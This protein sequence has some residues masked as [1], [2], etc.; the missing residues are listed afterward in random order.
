MQLQPGLYRHYKGPHYR[1]FGTA[2]HSET[3]E[4]LVVYQALYGE[5]GLWVRPLEMFCGT[6]EVD[7]ETLPR[8]A[9]IE[10]QPA[11]FTQGE[12][13]GHA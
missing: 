5:F 9:L 8:F 10:A 7:G 6:V 11:L 12:Q 1:V 4:W 13:D 3:E 2:R